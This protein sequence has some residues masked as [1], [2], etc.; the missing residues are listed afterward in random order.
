MVFLEYGQH[1]INQSVNQLTI[2]LNRTILVNGQNCTKQM[3][4]VTHKRQTHIRALTRSPE[5]SNTNRRMYNLSSLQKFDQIKSR[6]ASFFVRSFAVRLSLLSLSLSISLSRSL[7]QIKF[8]IYY[9][10][11]RMPHTEEKREKTTHIC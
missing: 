9:R 7:Y 10:D 3:N 2:H 5:Y 6:E 4:D 8:S 1:T 11:L